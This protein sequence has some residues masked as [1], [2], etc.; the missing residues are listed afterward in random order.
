MTTQ[1]VQRIALEGGKDLQASL[2]AIGQSG[3]EA[4]SALREGASNASEGASAAGK[5]V[6]QFNGH[7][8][9]VK[10]GAEEAKSS[11]QDMG[12]SFVSIGLK[13]GAAFAAVTASIALLTSQT[14]K[15]AKEV[16]DEKDK[17]KGLGFS[18]DDLQLMNELGAET[19]DLESS[20]AKLR[21]EMNEVAN[22]TASAE[23]SLFD[24]KIRVRDAAGQMREAKDVARDLI[25]RIVETGGEFKNT[26]IQVVKASDG[27]GALSSIV[28]KAAPAVNSL[29]KEL[30]TTAELTRALGKD[31]AG[32]KDAFTASPEK[33]K[34][35]K[36]ALEEK[37]KLEKEDYEAAQKVKEADEEYEKV[38]GNLWKRLSLAFGDYVTETTKART[39]FL[40][41]YS[42]TFLELANLAASMLKD[43]SAALKGAM[44]GI[45]ELIP[46]DSIIA[47]AKA[48]GSVIKSLALDVKTL[49]T[50]GFDALPAESSLRAIVPFVKAVATAIKDL[51]VQV[52]TLFTK[53]VDALPVE[54]AL[55]LIVTFAKTAR[56]AFVALGSAV[57]EAI[58]KETVIAAASAVGQAFRDL[59]SAIKLVSEGG[60]VESLPVESSLRVTV[61]YVRQAISFF[62]GL[63]NAV[64]KVW[65]IIISGASLV[66][67][68]LKSLTGIDISP[69]G[70]IFALMFFNFVGVLGAI[71]TALFALS[72][73]VSIV[74]TAFT[75]FITL[76]S[77]LGLPWTLAIA[78]IVTALYA[79]Y[80]NWDSIKQGITDG[81]TAVTDWF[82]SKW[83]AVLDWLAAKWAALKGLF[84]SGDSSSSSSSSAEG[85][86]SGGLV[87]GPGTSTSDSVRAW[88]SNGEFV[89]NARAVRS[90]G[91]GTLH[92]INSGL[93]LATGGYVGSGPTVAPRF[94]SAATSPLR[95][96]TVQIGG[97][98]FSGLLAPEHVAQ[99][100]VRFATNKQARSMGSKPSWY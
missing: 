52:F 26:G 54:S 46:K 21:K 66:T 71:S 58:P 100:L 57:Y 22:G 96:L 79:L 34:E 49:F 51:S 89:V 30:K 92:A 50:K 28:V 83:S 61:G 44:S 35:A 74:G 31:G 60:S 33:I 68:A 62:D 93:R 85:H 36:E 45:G 17:A 2:A 9:E 16:A 8:K 82:R 4:F 14:K 42:G 99:S 41:D 59:A 5:S 87:R 27:L 1:L 19:K 10:A 32:L 11:L 81:V 12:S 24:Y 90:V 94:S 47:G 80:T 69:E 98:T 73:I 48:V 6:Q 67:G 3:K 72:S 56:D 77:A 88:L 15:A 20:F 91:V 76:A 37:I 7:L 43:I 97:E 40:K 53:G 39:E 70:L 25:A 18:T 86:A 78:G 64:V 84:S 65:G 38:S 23:N 13:I 95:P 63:R 29:G 75:G 55:R